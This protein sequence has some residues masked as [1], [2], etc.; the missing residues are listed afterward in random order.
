VK[1][2]AEFSEAL[3]EMKLKGFKVTSHMLR[4]PFA[5][6]MVLAQWMG[7]CRVC[8]KIVNAGAAADADD[9]HY[10]FEESAMCD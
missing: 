7:F 6:R 1:C 2:A 5:R 8:R 4:R 9:M 3:A 10:T